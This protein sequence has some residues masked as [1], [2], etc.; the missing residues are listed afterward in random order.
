MLSYLSHSIIA[1]ALAF[2]AHASIPAWSPAAIAAPAKHKCTAKPH[3][4]VKQVV[5]AKPEA[6][7]GGMGQQRRLPDVQVISFGP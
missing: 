7:G 5:V 4:H 2:T 1:V 6:R 3:R